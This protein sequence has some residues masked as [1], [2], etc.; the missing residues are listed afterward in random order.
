MA[1]PEI[2]RLEAVLKKSTDE[3][4]KEI[5]AVIGDAFA[6]KNVAALIKISQYGKRL[7]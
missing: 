2:K 4:Q 7:R 5:I 6:K 3:Q 1:D